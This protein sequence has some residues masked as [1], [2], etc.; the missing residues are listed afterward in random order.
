MKTILYTEHLTGQARIAPFAGWDMP[1]QYT[2]IVP[3]HLHTRQQASVFDISHMGEFELR[4]PTAEQDLEQ[5]VTQAVASLDVGQCRYGYLLNPAGGVLDDLTCYRLGPDHFYLV[6]NA[7]NRTTNAA[8]IQEHCQRS[9]T[10]TDVS[11]QTAKIDIQG[12]ASRALT[13]EA[14]GVT[15]PDLKYFRATHWTYYGTTTLLSRTGY[16]GEWGYEW[17][18]PVDIAVA[19][20]RTLLAPGALQP[21]GL[22]A[23]DTLRLEIGYPLHGHEL[24]P[25]RSPVAAAGR[26]FMQLDK[27]FIGREAVQR[28]LE[29]GPAEKLMGLRLES[30]RAARAGDVVWHGTT[31]IGTVTSGSYAPSLGVAIALAYVS[32]EAAEPGTPCE[33]EVRS[34]RLPATLCRPPF[35]TQGT[36]RRNTAPPAAGATNGNRTV[37]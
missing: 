18:L 3:E 1:I 30:R 25:D 37:V 14:L 26:S 8:W 11:D 31:P 15:L 5:L 24:T 22:G 10:F 19:A 23:R 6:V 34:Q 35:Y 33:I 21:A 28:V 2:G 27:S 29:S 16:T 32:T 9:T 4:G 12:P 13:E 36:A 17:Y 20:W 7:A